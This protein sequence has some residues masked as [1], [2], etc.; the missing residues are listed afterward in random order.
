MMTR[1]TK[2]LLIGLSPLLLVGL[3]GVAFVLPFVDTFPDMTA[4][5]DR[6]PI[7]EHWELIGH[8]QGG[9]RSRFA[10]APDPYLRRSYRASWEAGALCS[11]VSTW[12]RHLLDTRP[13]DAGACAVRFAVPSGRS[14]RMVNVWRY[15]VT[16]RV[17]HP[18]GVRPYTSDSRCEEIRTQAEQ[19]G[20]GVWFRFEPCWVPAGDA[21]ITVT[22]DGKVGI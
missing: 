17:T 20:Q 8:K 15:V 12:A 14:A 22:L 3:A 11:E 1:R 7:P 5:L 4:Q 13:I 21:L 10:A 6:V 18:D 19:R 2:W 16:V 9:L